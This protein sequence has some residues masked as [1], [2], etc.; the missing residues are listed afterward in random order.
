MGWGII[1]ASGQTL[2]LNLDNSIN[3]IDRGF[4]IPQTEE[5][6][7]VACSHRRL[8]IFLMNESFLKEEREA[9]SFFTKKFPPRKINNND[10]KSF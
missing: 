9:G 4:G 5:K 10:S 8:I 3:G 7:G 1:G 2:F 6:G